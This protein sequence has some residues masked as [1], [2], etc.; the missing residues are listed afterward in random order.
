MN[1]GEAC[2]GRSQPVTSDKMYIPVAVNSE[3]IARRPVVLY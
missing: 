2:E 1:S 3:T